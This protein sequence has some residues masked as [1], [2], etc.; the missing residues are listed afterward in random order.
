MYFIIYLGICFLTAWYHKYTKAGY[1]TIF[2]VSLFL[3]PLIGVAV[4]ALSPLVIEDSEIKTRSGIRVGDKEGLSPERII[5][6]DR[7]KVVQN[8]RKSDVLDIINYIKI[9]LK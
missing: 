3:T 2:F 4:G 9:K 8:L 7:N 1:W 6:V 5:K